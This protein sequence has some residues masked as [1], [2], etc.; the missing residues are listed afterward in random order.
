VAAVASVI[1]F[2]SSML[3]GAFAIDPYFPSVPGWAEYPEPAAVIQ[4]TLLFN[5]GLLLV[6]LAVVAVVLALVRRF[7]VPEWLRASL[8][9]LT[10][11]IATWVVVFAWRLAGKDAIGTEFS[12]SNRWLLV[13]FVS[14]L[15]MLWLGILIGGVELG[16]RPEVLRLRGRPVTQ[17]S[18]RR[19]LLSRVL[20]VGGLMVWMWLAP[21]R[22]VDRLELSVFVT[23]LSAVWLWRAARSVVPSS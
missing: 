4:G 20:A 9:V 17:L 18:P 14:G 8:K 3:F 6:V 5:G 13:A 11:S 10:V 21:W 1:G 23:A 16:I 2:L 7:V 22:T 15:V 12:G 19:L